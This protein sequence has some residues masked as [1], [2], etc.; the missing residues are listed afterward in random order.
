MRL[1][2]GTKIEFAERYLPDLIADYL[3]QI[4]FILQV[5]YCRLFAGILHIV[6]RLFADLLL[7]SSH[8]IV[9]NPY[10]GFLSH[11]HPIYALKKRRTKRRN[12]GP[13]DGQTFI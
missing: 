6:C 1:K 9:S 5:V 7:V 4:F 2:E 3:L 10:L 13:T 11:F 8:R 12:D